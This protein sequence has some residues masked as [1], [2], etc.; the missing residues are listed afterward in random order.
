M[1]LKLY[2]LAIVPNKIT[3]RKCSNGVQNK[4][5]S[6]NLKLQNSFKGLLPKLMVL[7]SLLKPLNFCRFNNIKLD[8]IINAD[9][10]RRDRLLRQLIVYI[11][12]EVR[13]LAHCSYFVMCINRIR[14]W[15][16][17][18]STWKNSS[19]ALNLLQRRYLKHWSAKSIWLLW[20]SKFIFFWVTICCND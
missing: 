16:N 17:M 9:G 6:D 8:S 15:R 2:N 7:V 18:N 5:I 11:D 3:Y 10:I 1:R 12:S 14:C 20:R 19:L 4:S 13:H